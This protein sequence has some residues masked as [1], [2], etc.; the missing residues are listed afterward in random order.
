MSERSIGI[1]LRECMQ[2]WGLRR[3]NVFLISKGG[4]ILGKDHVFRAL[5]RQENNELD[6]CVLS[7]SAA[8]CISPAF[9]AAEI[10]QSLERMGVDQIDVYMLNC[11]ERLLS[12]RIRGNKVL[13]LHPFLSRAF[14][15]LEYE[16]KTGRIGSYGIASNSIANSNSPDHLRLDDCLDIAREVG[17]AGNSFS[18]IEYPL[19]IFERDAL[20]NIEGGR[21]LSEL[22]EENLIYQFTQRPLNVIASGAVRCLGDRIARD[23]D[24]TALTSALSALFEKVANLELQIPSLVGATDDDV[25]MVSRFIWAETLSENLAKLVSS[26]AFATMHY[27]KTT[28]LPTLNSDVKELV[29][30]IPED[31]RE[32]S[33][34]AKWSTDYLESITSLCQLI[35]SLCLVTEAAT[36]RELSSVLCAMAPSALSQWRR[37][38]FSDQGKDVDM[39]EQPPLSD[40]AI[41]VIR[42]ALEMHTGGR[43]GTVLVGMRRQEYVQGAVIAG[44]GETIDYGDA[45]G[46]L[47]CSLLR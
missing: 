31:E 16:V 24:E 25:Q 2:E 9:I 33:A 6:V 45:E 23:T 20:E 21:I 30:T 46:A 11:P 47:M 40:I 43:G 5:E 13:N 12:G 35:E 42:A 22:A 19:N 39:Y 32:T 4:H 41:R 37:L 29:S 15:H 10:S 1:V 26:S 38:A 28:V 27:I 8:H 18:S 44:S 34:V 3:E 17:G 14:A 7:E 36:N